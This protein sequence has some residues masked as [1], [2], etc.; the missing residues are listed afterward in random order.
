MLCMDP[1][2]KQEEF[3]GYEEGRE[4]ML[5]RASRGVGRRHNKELR[6][7]GKEPG[8]GCELRFS[9]YYMLFVSLTTCSRVCRG[10][11]GVCRG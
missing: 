8:K 2:R 9:S 5:M 7:N 3:V 6:W 1:S 10:C 4:G 11:H